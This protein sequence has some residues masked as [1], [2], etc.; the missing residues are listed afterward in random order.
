MKAQN[1]KI[2]FAFIMQ[3]MQ[4][5][6]PIAAQAAAAYFTDSVASLGVTLGHTESSLAEAH[7]SLEDVFG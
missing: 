3:D 4:S 5:L 2:S 6:L 1:C 7:I